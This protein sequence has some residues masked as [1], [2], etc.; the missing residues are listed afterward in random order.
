M[1]TDTVRPRRAGS[2]AIYALA[3]QP[4]TPWILLA[5]AML[6][7]GLVLVAP[8]T[9]ALA[10]ATVLLLG[11]LIIGRMAWSLDRVVS[12]MVAVTVGLTP[13][14]GGIRRGL[15][16]PV[17]RLSELLVAV[18][19]ACV[20]GVMLAEH[21]R[22]RF[23]PI[24][25]AY[26]V[27]LL[28]GTAVPVMVAFYT[29]G[30]L[31]TDGWSTFLGPVKF[32]LAYRIVVDTVRTDSDLRRLL[33]CLLFAGAAVAVVGIFEY[34]NVGNLQSFLNAYF[35]EGD[36]TDTWQQ[37]VADTRRI[38]ATVGSWNVSG[39]FFAF[40]VALVIALVQLRTWILRRWMVISV[41]AICAV[42]LLLSGSMASTLGLCIAITTYAVVRHRVPR[43]T[44]LVSALV[45][46]IL[47]GILF[48]PFL[49]VRLETQYPAG[50]SELIPSSVQYRIALW[51]DQF[52]PALRDHEILGLGPSLPSQID[53]MTEESQYLFNMYKG[54]IPYLFATL[55]LF[56]VLI[57]QL[58][59]RYPY[60]TGGQ[61][62][63]T[64]SALG[65]SVALVVINLNNAYSTYGVPAQTFWVLVGLSS[66]RL[67]TPSREDEEEPGAP[68]DV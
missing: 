5:A 50:A 38:I 56:A 48:R 62:A 6:S 65:L 10:G 52:L 15:L 41:G 1:A 57:V 25:I 40:H 13:L 49:E 43:P 9:V 66:A 33:I 61:Q 53:W 67:Q 2:S 23:G 45:V 47:A 21:R 32:Y 34:F 7:L 30:A 14:V 59:R 46:A 19:F 39:A 58:R 3:T 51:R 4:T 17:V 54:G 20:V 29:D 27:L 8:P 31:S 68:W 55:G 24:D 60:Q 26:G 22:P 28:F 44:I 16:I 18:T 37:Q 64:L 42:G 35:M 36:L 11:G 63:A 12:M